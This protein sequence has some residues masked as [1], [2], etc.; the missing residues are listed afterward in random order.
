MANLEGRVP[1]TEGR[2]P[3]IQTSYAHEVGLHD[4]GKDIPSNPE[5]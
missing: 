5:L 2:N 1:V 4:G 3:G